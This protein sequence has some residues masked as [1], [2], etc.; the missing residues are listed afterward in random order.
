MSV[1]QRLAGRLVDGAVKA[2]QDRAPGWSDRAD[3]AYRA[4]AGPLL[5]ADPSSTARAAEARLDGIRDRVGGLA[6]RGRVRPAD[7]RRIQ[8]DLV[9]TREDLTRAAP[10]LPAVRARGLALRLEAYTEVLGRLPDQPR[11]EQSSRQRAQGAVILAGAAGTEIG[12]LV[13]V[14]GVLTSVV[15]GLAGGVVTAR[16]AT[17]A[18][19]RRTTRARVGVLAGELSRI[20]STS[21]G[22]DRIDV[23]DRD[24][25]ALMIR[26]RRS[27]RLDE[28]G[29]ATLGR[30]DA[31]LDDLLIRLLE[32][33]LAADAAHLV[34]ASVTRYL[35]DT[36]EPFLALRDPKAVVRGQ[37][38]AVEVAAQLAAI[39]T[40]L[41]EMA[42]RPRGAQ[43]ETQ[44]LLQGEFLRSKFG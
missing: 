20:D 21:R 34:Q 2:V 26:T 39:E 13:L 10:Q 43:L 18:L 31:H 25:Q 4:V 1:G 15:L 35:P 3:R 19:S 7:T 9:R 38:A 22:P 8:R 37:P 32:G 24:R 42:R 30:I 11:P 6:E 23:L 28:N 14:T 29:L 33:D 16:V 44:L 5:R 17:A 12:A 41:A 40:G 36:L 27:G